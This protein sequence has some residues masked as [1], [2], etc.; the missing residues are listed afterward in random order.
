MRRH[1]CWEYHF[2][3]SQN[4]DTLYCNAS[5]F[6]AKEVWGVLSRPS[7]S[8]TLPRLPERG[9]KQG[10]GSPSSCKSEQAGRLSSLPAA[11]SLRSIGGYNHYELVAPAKRPSGRAA[12]RALPPSPSPRPAPPH[13]QPSF[14]LGPGVRT[15]RVAYL[16]IIPGGDGGGGGGSSL[17]ST[18]RCSV[19]SSPRVASSGRVSLHSLA[20]HPRQHFTHTWITPEGGLLP[21]RRGAV[22][23][24]ATSTEVALP[25]VTRRATKGLAVVAP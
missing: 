13:P 25:T 7:C 15:A 5:Y 12:T 8:V 9:R 4:R 20:S 6:K 16:F 1:P 19:L 22:G 2:L 23:Q 11:A 24:G 3:V 10:K 14:K 18:Q 17:G 21:P